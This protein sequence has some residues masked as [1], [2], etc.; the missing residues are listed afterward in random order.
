MNERILFLIMLF[1][2]RA[3]LRKVHVALRF[4]FGKGEIGACG[5]SAYCSSGVGKG[6]VDYNYVAALLPY[7]CTHSKFCV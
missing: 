5:F 7:V 4:L 2:F 3:T 1:V 6:G